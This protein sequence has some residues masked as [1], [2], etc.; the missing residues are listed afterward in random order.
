MVDAWREQIPL[1]V[2]AYLEL[3]K[4]GPMDSASID[5]AWAIEVIGFEGTW[6]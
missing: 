2:D 5:G 3:Q 1:L 4:D 6:Q